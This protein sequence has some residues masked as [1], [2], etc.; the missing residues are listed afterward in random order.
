MSCVQRGGFPC[1]AAGLASGA[2]V[3]N[4][5]GPALRRPPLQWDT[6]QTGV[7]RTGLSHRWS[8]YDDEYPS[9]KEARE[10]GKEV[11]GLPHLEHKDSLIEQKTLAVPEVKETAEPLDQ[12]VNEGWQLGSAG[13]GRLPMSKR[14]L[15]HARSCGGPT[16]KPTS[17]GSLRQTPVPPVGPPLS[18]PAE[19][20]ETN[21]QV[22]PFGGGALD[23]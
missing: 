9:A 21:V 1:E 22:E 7:Y 17:L 10:F 15:L 13:K 5:G 4:H 16:T 2:D 11:L 12:M 3:A 19:A 8:D 14:L 6:P 20:E 18:P 23:I